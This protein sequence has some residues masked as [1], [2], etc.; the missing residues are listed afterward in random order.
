MRRLDV[1]RFSGMF[2]SKRFFMSASFAFGIALQTGT[3]NAAPS[4]SSVFSFDG[5]NGS[6]PNGKVLFDT[7]GNLYGTTYNGGTNGVGTIFKLTAGPGGFTE[8]VLFNF[9][10]LN[11]AHPTAGLVMDANGALYGTAST[12]SGK[13]SGVVFQLTPSGGAYTYQVIHSFGAAGD[14]DYPNCDLVFGPK[15]TLYGTTV[16]GGV[17][18]FGTVFELTPPAQGQTTWTESV[19]YSF[20]GGLDGDGPYAGV[21]FD[22]AGNLY[23]TTAAGGTIA[24]LTGNG[25]VFKLA[26]PTVQGGSW[27]ETTLYDFLGT[28]DG[29]H[30]FCEL[31]I[32]SKGAIFGTT[33]IGGAANGVVF[34]LVPPVTPGN[35]YT[36]KVVYTFQGTDGANPSDALIEDANGNLFGTTGGAVAGNN[37][38]VFKLT[39]TGSGTFTETVLYTF[40]GGSDGQTPLASLVQDQSGALYGTAFYRGAGGTGSIFAIK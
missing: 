13:L 20:T 8:S 4:F 35:P 15:G 26:P 5:L 2:L 39:P 14:G 7:Q 40:A 6:N 24:G 36:E 21:V 34:E 10:G 11:G 17:E 32:G 1:A 29:N 27:T 3:V 37:G 38:N 18:G 30:P 9:G 12:R 33:F 19:I 31:L 22:T 23:G 25:S 16:F 28:T